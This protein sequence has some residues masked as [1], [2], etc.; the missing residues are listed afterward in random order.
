MFLITQQSSLLV[1]VL[2]TVLDSNA[3]TFHLT[4]DCYKY[5]AKVALTHTHEDD[6]CWKQCESVYEEYLALYPTVVCI[7]QISG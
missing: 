4:W 1:N 2:N 7:T 3:Q 5:R 6:P